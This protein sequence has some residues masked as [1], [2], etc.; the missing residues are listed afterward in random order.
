MLIRWGL[1]LVTILTILF[2][3]MRYEAAITADLPKS[4]P[5]QVYL[6]RHAEKPPEDA[7]S[8][9]LNDKG[10]ER[11]AALPKLFE[12]SAT[13]PEPLAKPD[14]IFAGANT[15]KSARSSLT[16]A[17][18][19]AALKMPVN[20]KIEKDDF[21]SLA[22]ELLSNAKYSGKTVLVAWNHSNLEGFAKTLGAKKAPEWKDD[23][24]DRVWVLTWDANGKVTFKDLPQQLLPGDSQK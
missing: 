14:F 5:R 7:M 22:R 2:A 4:H 6:I 23:V 21:A 20:A 13:R 11:A 8:D 17:P 1:G 12:K 24:F 16:V 10:K 3:S 15:K 19:A 9:Q 18:F